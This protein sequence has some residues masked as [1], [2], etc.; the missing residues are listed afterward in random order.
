VTGAPEKKSRETKPVVPVV[1][2]IIERG[3]KFLA[4]RRAPGQSNAGLWEFPGGKVHAEE[5]PSDALVRELREE[6]GFDVKPA[7]SLSSNRHSYPWISIELIPFVCTIVNGEPE[8]REH[9]E[10]RWVDEKEALE[11]EWAEADKPILREYL[12][13]LKNRNG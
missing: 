8:P 6:L 11:L 12:T 5:T 3:P 9:A 10:I 1:C 13:L 7:A 2:A 4:A